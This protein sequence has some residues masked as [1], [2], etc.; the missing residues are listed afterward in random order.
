MTSKSV[1]RAYRYRF[2]PTGAQAA[3]LSRTFG[4]VR[5]VYNR[6]LAER[7]AAWHQR[8]ERVG[9][10]QTSVMLTAWKRS[11]ELSFL[12]EVSS[13]PLQQT[14]RHLHTA[15]RNFFDKRAR[16][17]RFK[18]KKTSRASAEYTRSAFRYRDG[19]LTL[20]KMADPLDIV[21]S[22]PLP[23]G[24]RPSTVTVSRDAAGRWFVSLLCEDTITSAPAIRDAVGVDMGVTS[25]MALSTGEKVA[26][27][28]HEQRDRAR[29][30]R[31]QRALSR[32]QPGSANRDKARRK[33]A[34]VHA[35]ITDRR[36]DFLH[37]LSSRL[38]RENQA[39][40][41]E[42]LAVANMVKNRRLSRA[43]SDVAWRELR[44]ML[45][46][47]CAWYGRDLVVVDRFFPS[48]KACSTP[49]CGYLHASLPLRVRE[50]TCPRCGVAHDRD[51]NAALNLEAA[52]LAVVAC[53]AGVRPQ[54]ESSRT[55]RPA[56]KQEGHGATRDEALASNHR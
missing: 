23:E 42:D 3:E 28:R 8:Q 17:P 21:W 13:V 14:L 39:V 35:R 20:A 48:S 37:K 47:K 1:K 18:S 4:C 56:T 27:P 40:V 54:R 24:A 30:A 38:V 11:E 51:V 44:S 9:Y 36:R 31:A 34:R 10:S 26:N 29:L 12:A 41:I 52:G 16:Y 15:F 2:Y 6:A 43:I 5:L 7:T 46:Y 33:V 50:W 32:K 25:L 45:E 22:R 55:G 53:G 49:G 19:H